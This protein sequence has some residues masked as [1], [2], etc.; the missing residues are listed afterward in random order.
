[1]RLKNNNLETKQLQYEIL[2]HQLIIYILF[3]YLHDFLT[4]K[5]R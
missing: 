1:M 2:F 3:K 4:E 5:N